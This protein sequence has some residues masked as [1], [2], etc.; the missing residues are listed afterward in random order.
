MIPNYV[1]GLIFLN[2]VFVRQSRPNEDLQMIDCMSGD[3]DPVVST[4][5]V[6]C[7]KNPL[8]IYNLY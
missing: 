1:S 2:I 5:N 4:R 7:W 3:R 8:I 6:G